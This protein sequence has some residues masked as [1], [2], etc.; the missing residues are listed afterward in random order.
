M[1]S[2]KAD[3]DGY[4]SKYSEKLDILL[5]MTPG[6]A[7]RLANMCFYVSEMALGKDYEPWFNA[8]W[9]SSLGYHIR[10]KLKD[11]G[12]SEGFIIGMEGK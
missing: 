7:R 12:I 11:Q 10:D 1:M 9:W 6:E 8:D 2:E 4:Q 3:S 5:R